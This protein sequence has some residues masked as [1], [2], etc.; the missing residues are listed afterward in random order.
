MVKN[1]AL[2]AIVG[3]FAVGAV[4]AAPEHKKEEA[5]QVPASTDANK[6][7]GAAH[8]DKKEEEKKPEAK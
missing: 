2:A 4:V 1:I 7:A 5:T 3:L 6:D 8:A